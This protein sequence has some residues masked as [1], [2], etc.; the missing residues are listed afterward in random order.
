M[1]LWTLTVK[2]LWERCIVCWFRNS[3][4]FKSQHI[5][6]HRLFPR[7]ELKND[8][9]RFSCC[10]FILCVTMKIN[11]TLATTF[12]RFYNPQIIQVLVFLWQCERSLPLTLPNKY[13]N[14]NNLWII[15]FLGYLLLLIAV[16]QKESLGHYLEIVPDF[17]TDWPNSLSQVFFITYHPE[18]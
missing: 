10:H 11:I 12:R 15:K 17:S 3:A 13:Q 4:T 9:F 16:A 8:P 6:I 18:I 1:Y 14:L 7:L 5:P 2:L